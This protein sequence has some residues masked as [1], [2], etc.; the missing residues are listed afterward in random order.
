M[1]KLHVNY[2]SVKL[3]PEKLYM[4]D[5]CAAVTRSKSQ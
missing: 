5:H 3:L 1:G 4:K 2:I